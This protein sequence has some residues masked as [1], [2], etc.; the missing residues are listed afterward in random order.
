MFSTGFSVSKSVEGVVVKDG[1][2]PK[3]VVTKEPV[4]EIN[5]PVVSLICEENAVVCVESIEVST[6]K[7]VEETTE[8]CDVVSKICFSV[9]V[10]SRVC[11]EVGVENELAVE[12]SVI[13]E[14]SVVEERVEVVSLGSS[15]SESV[16]IPV[17]KDVDCP[18]LVVTTEPVVE[19]GP[20][21]SELCD[22]NVVVCVARVVNSS[23]VV[24]TFERVEVTIELCEVVSESCFSVVV[25]GDCSKVVVA[26]ELLVIDSVV[27]GKSVVE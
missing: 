10:V 18:E 15:V 4:V 7:M 27:C 1:D 13:W 26:N 21:E 6:F 24:S 22:E 16:E 2:C 20:V 25:S 19:T 5:E 3:V 8:L 17:V 11:S 12:E 9:V 14:K 23:V